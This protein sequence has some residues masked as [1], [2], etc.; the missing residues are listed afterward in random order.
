MEDQKKDRKENLKKW[1]N[2]HR[3]FISHLEE[4]QKK[5]K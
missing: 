5:P 4:Q 2:V 1:H 3:A